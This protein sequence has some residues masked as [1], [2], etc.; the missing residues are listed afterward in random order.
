MHP[1]VCFSQF[2]RGL[3]L[4]VFIMV[5][6]NRYIRQGKKGHPSDVQFYHVEYMLSYIFNGEEY[7]SVQNNHCGGGIFEH[8]QPESMLKNY[9][10]TVII[11]S[12]FEHCILHFVLTA[13]HLLAFIKHDRRT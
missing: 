1:W 4:M 11:S 13:L 6:T 5:T 9:S 8:Y 3:R 10:S 2:W 12:Y 7:I